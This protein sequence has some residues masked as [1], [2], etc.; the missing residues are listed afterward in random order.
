MM[1]YRNLSFLSSIFLLSA[2]LTPTIVSASSSNAKRAKANQM[3]AMLPASDVVATVDV[4]R[5]F[6]DAM[7]K[8][9]S[10]NQPMLAEWIG[11]VDSI[12]EKTGIDIR[13]FEFLTIGVNVKLV[14]EKNYEIE[15]VMLARGAVNAKD[16]IGAAKQA[17]N[18]RYREETINGKT[19]FTFAMSELAEKIPEEAAETA[20]K[21]MIDK[22][23]FGLSTDISIS[24]VDA[25]TIAIGTSER[26]RTLLGGRS[27]VGSDVTRL[28]DRKPFAVVNF[29]GKVPGGLKVYLPLE[30]DDLG[31]SIDAIR[32]AYGSMDVINSEVSMSL[33][34]RLER[35]SQ[36]EQLH[37]TLDLL[38]AVAGGTLGSSRRADQQ[39][40]ARLIQNLKLSRNGNEISIDLSI[41]QSDLDLLVAMLTK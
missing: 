30:S 18:G 9:L 5:F 24:A 14:S 21:P 22:L 13:Q 17:S 34:A 10:A 38:K 19:V 33:S 16:V 28:L 39:L 25:N 40:Y 7:P 35:A 29:A 15:P 20:T 37:D 32:F 41:P 3:V 2:L 4:K 23:L 12:R 1:R 11:K 31:N 26:V 6:D 36:S 27:K 8:I